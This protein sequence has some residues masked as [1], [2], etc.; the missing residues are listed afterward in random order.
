MT[1][2]DRDRPLPGAPEPW[3]PSAMPVVRP[4]PP[5]LMTEMIAA[6]PAVAERIAGRLPGDPAFGHLVAELE[7]AAGTR[8][9][10]LVTGCGTSEHAA[11]AVA[12]VLTDTLRRPNGHGPR[13]V[14]ALDI[15][16][17]PPTDGLL[18]AI[19][20]E[21]GTWATNEAI[22]AARSSGATTAII[23]VSGRSPGAE[24]AEIVVE[25][26]E[27]DQSWCHTIG[28]LS[29]IVV[30]AAAG[31][32]LAGE[33]LDVIALRAL[34]DVADDPHGAA[35]MAAALADCDRLIV[36]GVGNDL[37]SVRELAL[38]VEEGARLPATAHPLENVLHGHLAAAT[39]RTGFVLVLAAVA[40]LVE[41][42]RERARTILRAV[43]L[44][45]MPAAAILAA[46]L[47]DEIAMALTPAGRM[48]VAHAARLQSGAG[49]VLGSAIPLQLLAERLARARG[50]NPDTLG[51]EET[52]QARAHA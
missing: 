27:Q 37:A 30:A 24:A 25:T 11:M 20:H 41:P 45:H 15:V 1:D 44:L 35:S 52:A 12:A 8:A 42:I 13:A 7:R 39:P 29:P 33:G 18:V 38:K 6:E 22:A 40:G 34:L 51:R 43:G 16:R 19:S 4:G 10:V 2:H 46:D 17:D 14:Q 50:V 48:A 31:S 9:P 36:A 47:G 21:G 23:T 28:Y 26:R 49:A 32:A 3:V 5:Y